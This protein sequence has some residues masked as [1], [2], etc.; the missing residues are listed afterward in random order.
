MTKTDANFGLNLQFRVREAVVEMTSCLT[1][2][3]HPNCT[4]PPVFSID[5]RANRMPRID[6]QS[7]SLWTATTVIAGFP[8]ESFPNLL[9]IVSTGNFNS[10]ARGQ[11]RSTISLLGFVSRTGYSTCRRKCDGEPQGK[12]QHEQ[13]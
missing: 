5:E 3:Y 8:L 6:P 13:E 9:L 1:T 10:A 11:V 12:F 2:P 7:Q 4:T